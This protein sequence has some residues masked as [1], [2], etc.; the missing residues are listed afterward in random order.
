MIFTC[1]ADDTEAVK[2]RCAYL[3]G[4]GFSFMVNCV[5]DANGQ[6]HHWEIKDGVDA[7]S[8]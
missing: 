5:K 3:I 6:I 1:S 8:G 4:Q 2:D 7:T